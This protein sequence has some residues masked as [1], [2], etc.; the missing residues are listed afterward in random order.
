MRDAVSTSWAERPSIFAGALLDPESALPDFLTSNRS[1]NDPQRFAVYRNNVTV[2]LVR[3]MEANFPTIVRLVGSEYFAGLARLFVRNYPPRTRLMFEYGAEFANFL[4]AFGPLAAYP[5]LGDVARLE[6]AWREAFHEADA[7]P[8]T[9][10]ELGAVPPGQVANLCFLSHPAARLVHSRFAAGS[11]FVANRQ[12]GETS[13]INP[14]KGETVLITR[15]EFDCAVRVL[16]AAQ[17]RFAELL[18]AGKLLGE[19]ATT[20]FESDAEFDLASAI[21]GLVG[22]G[23]FAGFSIVQG[24]QQ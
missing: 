1:G 18:L 24:E 21:S 16:D 23:A 2:G 22:S 11:I 20:A 12:A 6:T 19:A 7:V 17:G 5:Y 8:L 3:A 15:P 10:G 4:D 14:S 9:L 13:A